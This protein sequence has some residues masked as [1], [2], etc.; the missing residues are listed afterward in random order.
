MQ[1]IR[2]IILNFRLTT[3]EL[4]GKDSTAENE[5]HCRSLLVKR[6]T[7]ENGRGDNDYRNNGDIEGS[8]MKHQEGERSDSCK[9]TNHQETGN[10]SYKIVCQQAKFPPFL[11]GYSHNNRNGMLNEN[12]KEV[13]CCK[14]SL[15]EDKCLGAAQDASKELFDVNSNDGVADCKCECLISP[16][17]DDGIRNEIEAGKCIANAEKRCASSCR[18]GF[19]RSKYK[20]DRLELDCNDDSKKIRP[21]KNDI[22]FDMGKVPATMSIVSNGVDLNH[23]DHNESNRS[24]AGPIHLDHHHTNHA[25]FNHHHADHHHSNHDDLSHAEL[26]GKCSDSIVGK[27]DELEMNVVNEND[28]VGFDHSRNNERHP[29]IKREKNI[30]PKS[31]LNSIDSKNISDKSPFNSFESNGDDTSRSSF[32]SNKSVVN[33]NR[34]KRNGANMN[35]SSSESCDTSS[36]CVCNWA[37]CEAK[38][39]GAMELKSHVKEMHVKT[40]AASDLFFCFWKGCKVYNKPSSSYNWLVKHVNTHVGIRPFQC[41]IEPCSLSFASHGAL[42]R[43]VQS[44]FNERSKYY[45][46]PNAPTKE[47]AASPAGT[48]ETC[49]GS[50]STS[51]KESKKRRN[52]VFM[53][54]ARHPN[55]GKDNFGGFSD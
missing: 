48:E 32:R 55:S 2:F 42:I 26:N 3:K 30:A 5:I 19:I 34:T 37:N 12:G 13:C 6:D 50:E 27:S 15:C 51:S 41:V 17:S 44:H 45:K 1:K 14:R 24:H 38:L 43:H 22:F 21:K 49:S 20:H 18:N 53:R 10:S 23:S 29:T 33:H 46:K 7:S 36:S 52:C 54:R 47:I 25:H 9:F 11:N 28:C 16:I 39:S 40:M 4:V 31:E 8:I 35:G